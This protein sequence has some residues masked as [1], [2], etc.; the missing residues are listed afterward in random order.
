MIFSENR[1]RQGY[2]TDDL[3]I[4]L[5]FKKNYCFSA[6]LKNTNIYECKFVGLHYAYII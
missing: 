1:Y 6:L 4:G 2:F 5:Q 3:Y